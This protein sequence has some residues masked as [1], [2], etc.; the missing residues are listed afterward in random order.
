MISSSSIY[1]HSPNPI[2]LFQ[3]VTASSAGH[4]VL[5]SPSVAPLT[6]LG[7]GVPTPRGRLLF[8]VAL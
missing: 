5:E 6:R 2:D 7:S 8:L 1:Y 4:S 3:T